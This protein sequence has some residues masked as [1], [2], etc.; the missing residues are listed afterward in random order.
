MN[1]TDK[2]IESIFYPIFCFK[3]ESG[4]CNIFLGDL[5]HFLLNFNVFINPC[6]INSKINTVF[7]KRKIT[8]SETFEQSIFYHLG[9]R[10]II[11]AIACKNR[12][13]N[14]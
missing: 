13:K 3:D 5:S 9:C 7:K 1:E 2:P 11:P 10:L 14:M 6:A 8:E 12:A 4:R